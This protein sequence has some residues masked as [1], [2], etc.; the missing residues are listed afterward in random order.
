MS[1]ALMQPEEEVVLSIR[2]NPKAVRLEW[3]KGPSK[4]REVIYSAAINDRMM[5][6]NSG[7]SALPHSPDVDPRGQPPGA[8]EQPAPDHR[9]R[10]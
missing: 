4:G 2:R 9:S 8:A 10:V 5:Y 6:V 3:A 7:N 1:A